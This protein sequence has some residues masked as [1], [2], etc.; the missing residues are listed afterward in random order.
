MMQ[1]IRGA[2]LA[3]AA[4][5]LS[6]PA[7]AMAAP[8]PLLEEDFDRLQTVESPA[9]T[10]D[11]NWIAYTVTTTDRAADELKS[12]VWLV[13][14]TGT[15]N[16]QLSAAGE[17]ATL[18]KF[19]PDGRYVAFLSARG[20][21]EAQQLYVLDRRGGEARALTHGAGDVVDYQWSPDGTRILLEIAGAGGAAGEEAATATS[22]AKVPKP[23]VIDAVHFK[24]D[25]SGYLTASSH[26]RLFLLDVVTRDVLPLTG[27]LHFREE[28]GVWSPDGKRIAYISNRRADADLSNV[29]E[30]YITTAQPGATPVRVAWG[31]APYKQ[32]LLFTADGKRVV[33]RVGNEPRLLAYSTDRLAWADAA[34]GQPV[35]IGQGLDRNVTA[36]SLTATPGVLSVL[37]EDDGSQYP[38]TLQLATGRVERLVP[39]AM[40]ATDQ[41]SAAGHLAVVAATDYVAPEIHAVENGRLRR[42]TNHNGPL[43]AELALGRVEDFKFS[44]RDGTEVHGILTKPVG[45]QPGRAYPT[46]L[47]I[48]GGPIGQDEH[49]L[50]F[51]TY[52]LALERQ[53]FAAHGYAAVAINYRGGSG[54]GAALQQAI[55]GD[56][57]HLEVEDLLAGID[58]L[59]KSGIADPQRLGV[60]GWS[61]GGILTDYVIA[62]DTRFK[63]AI[64]GAGSANQLTMFGTD[65][66]VTQYVHELGLP[67][68]NLEPWLKVS[69]AWLHAD[70][71][72]TPTLYLGGEKDFNVP[73]A[74]G[75]QMYQALRLQG[76]PTQLVVYPGQYH[77]F[78]RPSYIRDRIRR[79]LA[80]YDHYLK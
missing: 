16:W 41:C 60:G 34:G 27:D 52:P 73:I 20:G 10:A 80:W 74:G 65:E 56:W 68:T 24:Q 67:W 72:R 12:A 33:F 57:G 22:E 8:R 61:Y 46:I 37:V 76:V 32:G 44:S 69:Y 47:W 58:Y 43:L 78:T 42:L 49:G 79:Y 66:Y 15:E 3:G 9:C 54:R 26:S 4:W 11:G 48:H 31:Y 5:L 39:G 7:T 2:A 53:W 30:I 29:D 64:S 50:A 19:S 36:V 6:V 17:S 23:I 59:V 28:H 63:A 1:C 13:N 45:Y 18:P 77:I 40:S 38:A 35:V 55:A 51:D 75:E 70:R 14:W 25:R 62:S 71:N 21:A